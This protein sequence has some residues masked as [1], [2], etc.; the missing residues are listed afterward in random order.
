M[1]SHTQ[2]LLHNK[3][4]QRCFKI[5]NIHTI[6]ISHTCAMNIGALTFTENILPE[7]AKQIHSLVSEIKGVGSVLT[8]GLGTFICCWQFLMCV[9]RFEHLNY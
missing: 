6:S 8:T 3:K 2:Q 9:T 5:G 7:K 4:I 1:L